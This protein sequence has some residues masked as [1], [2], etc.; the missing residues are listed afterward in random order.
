MPFIEL[1]KVCNA[2]GNAEVLRDVSFT[3]KR[4]EVVSLIGPSGSGKSTLLRCLNFTEDYQEGEIW[5]DGEAVG[6]TFPGN[7]RRTRRSETEIA[8]FRT[9]VGMVYQNYNLFPHLRVLQNITLAPIKVLKQPADQVR[10]H[11]MELLEIVGL[12]DKADAFPINLSGGQQQRVAIA[13][14]LAMRPKAIL[15][16]E[17]TSA[18]DPE[19]VDEVLAV[20]RDLASA[21]MTMIVVTHE[22]RFAADVADQLIFMDKGQIVD[23][24]AP[25][26][27]FNGGGSER[28]NTFLRRFS[29]TQPVFC[30]A[31]GNVEGG[32][33]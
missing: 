12:A 11:A 9:R 8:R 22:I 23:R 18:L 15:F 10:Q 1:K 2:F 31:T 14:A 6:Y 33:K 20:M 3:V 16:D 17:V 5:V 30:G 7:G 32:M 4:G 28:L 25:E 13:R 24:G 21:G 27:L 29:S 19:L 26:Q